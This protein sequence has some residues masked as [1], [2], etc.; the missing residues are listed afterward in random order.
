MGCVSP[1]RGFT[2][3]CPGGR[4]ASARRLC[5]HATLDRVTT[6]LLP[7]GPLPG[8]PAPAGRRLRVAVVAETFYPRVDGSTTTVR[9]LVDRLV[10]LGHAVLLVAPAP[11]LTSFRGARVARVRTADRPGRVVRRQVVDA[12]DSFGPDLVHV[13]SPGRLGRPALAH[14]AALGVP[15]VVAQQDP[16]GTRGATRFVDDVL[17]HADRV[18]ATAPWMVE[19]LR[20]LGAAPTL[21]TPGV[22]TAAFTPALHDRWLHDRWAGRG[23]TGAPRP[24]V[25]GFVGTLRKRHGVRRLAE[26]AAVPG[27]RLVVVGE[28]PQRRWLEERVPGVRTTG[29]LRGGDLATAV[30][31]LDV[32]VHPSTDLTCAHALREAA[33][34]AVPVVAPRAG[35]APAVVRDHETGLLVDAGSPWGLRDAVAAVVADPRRAHL[36]ARARELAAHRSWADAVD[37]LVAG[38]WSQARGASTTGRAREFPTGR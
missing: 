1:R 5:A 29:A 37:D 25:V 30:A 14:A 27:V 26:V 24:V 17:P 35:G 9:A 18:V 23:A 31:S 6:T 10:D 4:L 16:L 7:T 11:G 21:W 3:S 38:A 22:D 36:G 15:T 28:G 8:Q 34:S 2:S 20:G 33:A 12:L 32:L 13:T 19:R